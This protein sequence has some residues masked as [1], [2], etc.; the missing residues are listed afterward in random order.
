M[1]YSRQRRDMSPEPSLQAANS[2]VDYLPLGM[3]TSHC[4]QWW[5]PIAYGSVTN[6]RNSSSGQGRF[7]S[8][9]LTCDHCTTQKAKKKIIENDG[10]NVA[11]NRLHFPYFSQRICCGMCQSPFSNYPDGYSR[12]RPQT[13]FEP[14]LFLKSQGSDLISTYF[15][16]PCVLL[17]SLTFQH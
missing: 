11:H 6:G 10:A 15:R 8:N 9:R 7:Y 12:P 16:Y 13:G 17:D 14:S 1:G 2:P 5:A 3:T 4:S